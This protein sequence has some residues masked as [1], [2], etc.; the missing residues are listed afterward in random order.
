M[1]LP[2]FYCPHHYGILLRVAFNIQLGPS[3]KYW[4]E[5]IQLVI[6]CWTP[7]SLFFIPGRLLSQNCSAL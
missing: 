4:F 2:H 5:Y 1:S 6:T 3:V 7:C